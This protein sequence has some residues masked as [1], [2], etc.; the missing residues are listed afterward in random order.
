M[1]QHGRDW[2]LW[3]VAMLKGGTR[4][5]T[6]AM[7]TAFALARQG[8][9]VLVVDA[10]AGTQGVTDWT[11][12]VY[13]ADPLLGMPFDVMQWAP[14]SGLLV[15][16]I[17]Q[18]QRDTGAKI[19]LVDVGGEQPEVIRQAVML[20]DL[21]V[22]PV[23]PE[24][25]EIGR[26]APTRTLIEPAGVPMRVLLT[27]VP[28]PGVGAAREVREQLEYDGFTVLKAETR[29]DRGRYAHVWGTIPQ[30]LGEY[31]DLPAELL[32]VGA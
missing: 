27:R 16:F 3:L 7:M 20:A 11:S 14:S 28:Q 13:A 22:T 9:D 10:D 15:P 25:A 18:A 12:R 19:V 5:T 30:D 17:Q 26:L 31:A 32:A 29:Q 21:V 8:H 24:Q 6:T 23:G 4:K 1:T 2:S